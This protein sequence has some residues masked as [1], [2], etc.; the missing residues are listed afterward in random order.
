MKQVLKRL[1]KEMYEY[2]AGT[3]EF[4]VPKLS[5]T[6][7]KNE[8]QTGEIIVK[9][10]LGQEF[11]GYVYSSHY[12]MELYTK[13]LEGGENTI[14]YVCDAAGMEEG[15]TLKGEISLISNTGQF[16]LPFE[17]TV[18]EEVFA[19]SMGPVK[20]LFHFTNMA[21]ND[22]NEA[23]SFF[24]SKDLFQILKGND[25]Q[26]RISYEGL[27]RYKGNQQNVEE[28]LLMIHKKQP[29]E[30]S[31]E[32]PSAQFEGVE[33]KQQEF[34]V[35]EK[36]GWGYS[37]LYVKAEGDFL[38]LEKEEI[39][40]ADFL[41]NRCHLP[42][43]IDAGK[44]H[45]GQNTGKICL[46]GPMF[47]MDY[48]IT[49]K[50]QKRFGKEFSY[51]WEM[52]RLTMQMLRL[53][54]DFRTQKISESVWVGSTKEVV[55]KM[56]GLNGR[57]MA[58][59][60]F[61]AQLL[62]TE[63]KFNEAK[64]ILRHVEDMIEEHGCEDEVYGYFF[65]V[66]SLYDKT[67]EMIET[68]TEKVKELLLKNP[69]SPQLLW[70]LLYL[71]EEYETDYARRYMLLEEAYKKGM[72]SPILY[73]E[74][75]LVLEKSPAYLAKL[76]SYEQQLLVFL[77]KHDLLTK[78]L[79]GQIIYLAG[80]EKEYSDKLF[81]ILKMCYQKTKDKETL[82][83][84]CN[85]LIKGNRTGEEWFF[86]YEA[87]VKEGLRITRLY[88]YYMLSL[89]K[90]QRELLPKTLLLYFSYECTMDYENT[91][92]IY[93]NITAHKK[94][95]PELYAVYEEQIKTFL[96]KQIRAAHINEDLAY[97]YKRI[98]SEH[99]ITEELAE[100]LAGLLFLYEITVEPE[101]M[102]Q[103]VVLCGQLEGERSY[104]LQD[105]KAQIPLYT[106]DY[107]LF[108]EDRW[109]NRYG[110][111][112]LYH[113]KRFLQPETFLRPLEEKVKNHPGFFLYMCHEQ[114]EQSNIH[115]SHM[116]GYRLL[117]KD[118]QIK[119]SYR[120]SLLLKLIPYLYEKDALEE[121]D[122]YLSQLELSCFDQ[123]ERAEMLSYLVIR[124]MYEKAYEAIC[125]LGFE[126]IRIRT[127]LQICSY[128]LEET[129]QMDNKLLELC[130]Y[131]FRQ[132]KYNEKVLAYLV[133]H[134]GGNPRYLRDIWQAAVSA[135]IEAY[136]LSERILL[137]C[138]FSGCFL[139]GK[140]EIFAYYFSGKP[141]E[142]I[143]EGYLSESA[144]EYFVKEHI[145]DE[146]FFGDMIA[147][148]RQ[149]GTMSQICMLA[150]LKY[151]SV[152][153]VILSLEEQQ[154][155]KDFLTE[156]FQKDIFFPF[157]LCYKDIFPAVI[158]YDSYTYIEYK[159]EPGSRAVIHYV[160][161]KEGSLN[162]KY[163]NEK[164]E[165]VYGGIFLKKFLLFFGERLQYYI[166]EEVNG[167]ETLTVS[168]TIEGNDMVAEGRESRF[169]LLN[170][171]A[172]SRNLEEYESMEEIAVEY[173]KKVW[174][175]EQ[176]FTMK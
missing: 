81:G 113:I 59:R 165:E 6:V 111:R 5:L 73:V 114:W 89:N 37:K 92:Y 103:V 22:W 45:E 9:S 175:C 143:V 148:Y 138:L 95:L 152:R 122:H 115:N 109:G 105:K 137:T 47:S 112:E 156:M 62:I 170:D 83:I 125:S 10:S 68:A 85:L 168:G 12:R 49:V 166:T 63:E 160:I 76:G 72:N 50:N 135:G 3:V 40:E 15:D 146:R 61:Q 100:G 134:A 110:S 14:S 119:K 57:N 154:M 25:R 42:Y 96:A 39:S 88:E 33:G 7:R 164:M 28:F 66:T 16:L 127:L 161:E 79:V 169:K 86:W 107:M 144:Y 82:G 2:A 24:Y 155:A 78:K 46:S 147:F 98:L 30:Y 48:E 11:C 1:K 102:K 8:K 87:A 41:G 29:M 27:S 70:M 51:K 139:S 118:A 131:V 162:S 172:V 36:N 71:K 158:L 26:Y 176:L 52:K 35:I 104:P 153:D 90:K 23:V 163:H 80:K 20:N 157:F 56:L 128:K 99:M 4:S 44:L 141:D 58:A 129:N 34:L 117:L 17:L 171:M 132:K 167:E 75:Y 174:Q 120:K 101:D 67:E 13:K 31:F 18:T 108:L 133:R 69:E 106:E 126:G 43:Y 124:E 32:Q 55:D 121:L 38:Q 150:F 21:K 84:I 74:A 149:K 136:G 142:Q 145:M 65:Y 130:R 93:A 97:L 19:S 64:W 123:K 159:G 53:Y 77:A 151:F 94:E 54:V 140:E 116:Y 60:L 91:A 173:A